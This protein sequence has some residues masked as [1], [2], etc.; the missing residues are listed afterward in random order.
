MK[1][2]QVSLHV[3]IS[4][5]WHFRSMGLWIYWL[6]VGVSLNIVRLLLLAYMLSK[7]SL[8]FFLPDNILI[9]DWSYFYSLKA[10]HKL[11]VL[12]TTVSW[13]IGEA[14]VGKFRV[15]VCHATFIFWFC[16]CLSW[17]GDPKVLDYWVWRFHIGFKEQFFPI[18]FFHYKVPLVGF[19]LRYHS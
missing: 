11:L 6:C 13:K 8:G 12:D 5:V 16:R 7:Q 17:R 3:V 19:R 18:L 1:V 10:S 9:E 4:A 15:Q 2:V 14:E